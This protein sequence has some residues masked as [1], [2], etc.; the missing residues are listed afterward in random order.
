[1]GSFHHSHF[2]GARNRTEI[3]KWLTSSQRSKL[4]NSKTLSSS[5]TALVRVLLPGVSVLHWQDALDSTQPTRKLKAFWLDLRRK[6]ISQ[7]PPT[8]PASQS[9][10]T[11]SCQ[12]SGALPP[13]RTQVHTRTSSRVLRS[14]TKTA[15]V[16]SP[17]P[18]C[19][20]S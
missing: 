7:P 12:S 2:E 10:S 20:T 14:S 18:S 8:W 4:K 9:H 5:L 16:P 13:P 6:R 11:T 1:M 17:P 19:V 15:M 3:S